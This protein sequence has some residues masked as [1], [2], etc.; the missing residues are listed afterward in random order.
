MSTINNELINEIRNKTDIISIIS[1]YLPLTK[2]GKNYFGV[3]PFHDDH[4]PSMSVSAEKQ[5]YTCF[6]CGASGNVFTFVSDYEH[7]SFVEAVKLLG[8]KVGIHLE[9][10]KDVS[11]N[12]KF[13]EY[14]QIY[15]LAMKFYQ[16]NINTSSGKN[17][18]AYLE[19]R[20]LGKEIVK[21]FGIGLS[22]KNASLI[23]ALTS[24]GYH[25][26]TLTLLGLTNDG[27]SDLFV[28]RI[29]FPLFDLN[30]QVVGFSGRIYNTKDTSKYVNSKETPIF[31]K[32]NLLYNY[33]NVK[34]HLKKTDTLILMEGFMDVIRASSIGIHNCV[35]SMGTAVTK[36]QAE[37]IKKTANQVILCFDGDAAGE[38][39][40]ISC[41]ALLEKI[42]VIPKV[43][44]LEE[45]LDP[46]EYILKYG[47]EA[48]QRKI[49]H[50][51][52]LLEFRMNLGKKNKNFND[53]KDISLYVNEML[54][55]LSKEKDEI[56]VNL[57][58]KKI[59]REFELDYDMLY[60][61]YLIFQ[62]EE[63]KQVENIV[64]K[65][66]KKGKDKYEIAYKTLIRYML[67]DGKVIEKYEKKVSYLPDDKL[68]Y[69]ANEI[70]Y[71]YHK[72]GV[73]KEAD[74]I[75]YMAE[76]EEGSQILKEILPIETKD[77]IEE[78]EILDYIHMIQEANVSRKIKELE[79][80][81][82]KELDP[83]KQGKIL[84][85]IATTRTLMER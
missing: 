71:Y 6:S 11:T 20:S 80:S 74:F 32:G 70:I 36:N 79:N 17:A 54:K 63:K 56:L 37:L 10:T 49:D 64:I 82:K 43:V 67:R 13:T 31:K 26:E 76:N 7:I 28:N 65:K 57:S 55:E 53:I 8:E 84:D 2:K 35:A 47:K 59:A 58:L 75:S 61:K 3:C 22:L 69:L 34:E 77:Q 50:P 68:R 81:L 25:M 85:E 78:E 62:K 72:Y 44:R 30:G 12:P 51:I 21:K 4:S 41:G 39:A 45:D 38:E 46:D 73:I 66:E 5:I 18:Y 27:S 29:M 33:H 9:N 19:K 52:S 24:K 1:N 42:G 23:Q 15:D 60:Q 16:N 48:F 83:I 14:F 40:T